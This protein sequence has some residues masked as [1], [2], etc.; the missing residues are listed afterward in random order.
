LGKVSL[1]GRLLSLGRFLKIKKSSP[2][3]LTTSFHC[4]GYMHYYDKKWLGLYFGRFFQNYLVTLLGS[5]SSPCK[6]S[7][8]GICAARPGLPLVYFQT[9]KI[10]IG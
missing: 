1:I 3:F 2:Y 6:L 10:Q 8:E 5:R 9:K 7:L 4:L